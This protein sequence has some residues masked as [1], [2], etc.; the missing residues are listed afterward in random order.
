MFVPDFNLYKPCL[1][2]KVIYI[3]S[4]KDKL[5]G[6]R[7]EPNVLQVWRIGAWPICLDLANP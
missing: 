2:R 4:I 6:P 1:S 3:L 5:Y 7:L